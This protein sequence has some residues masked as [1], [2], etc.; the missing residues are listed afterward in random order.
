[1]IRKIKK[2]LYFFVAGYFN[3]WAKIQLSLWKPK[4]IVITGSNGKTSTMHLVRSQLKNMAKYSDKANSAFGIPFDI[5][6]LKRKTFAPSEWLLLFLLAPLNSLRKINSK[7]LY[8]AEADAERPG[9]G[10]QLS[11]LLK[12]AITIWLNLGRTHSGNYDNLVKNG[13]FSNIDEAIADEFGKYL[14]STTD[15]CIINADDQMISSQSES[16]AA[17][18][19]KISENSLKKYSVTTKGSRFAIENK[20]IS[21]GALLPREFHYSIS[22]VFALLKELNITPD[23]SFKDF[24]LPAGRSSV[25]EG[26]SNTTIIDS[27]YNANLGSVKAILRMYEMVVSSNKWLILG[28]LIEQGQEEAEEHTKLIDLINSS[29]VNKIV[30]VGPRLKRYTFDGINKEKS[31]FENPKEALD[32]ILAT[33]TGEE[34]FLFKGA[35]FLEGIVEHLLKNKADVS[36]LC[37]REEVWQNRRKKWGL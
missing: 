23:Y 8:V 27:T 28:D 7:K 16:S 1:M 3:F 5:L 15:L 32:Y 36:K 20:V 31:V 22:A 13:K 35:R 6:N 17:K 37:R 33:M 26:I 21:F 4:I 34:I 9:E 11:S 18:K 14:V 29:N 24:H 30:L 25:F 10:K 19:I 2:Q 12:P